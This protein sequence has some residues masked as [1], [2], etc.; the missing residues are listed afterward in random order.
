MNDNNRKILIAYMNPEVLEA[1][2]NLLEDMGNEIAKKMKTK[3][4]PATELSVINGYLVCLN[5]IKI[6]V[7]DLNEQYQKKR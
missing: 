7:K 1:W 4:L 3:T 5:D 6:K 2:D